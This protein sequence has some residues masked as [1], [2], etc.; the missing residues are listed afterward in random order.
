MPPPSKSTAKPISSSYSEAGGRTASNNL[1]IGNLNPEITDSDLVALFEK[2]GPVDS[3]TNYSARSYGFVYYK[4]IEDAK[5]AKE[6]LQGTILHGNPIKIEFAKPAKPCK[7]LWVAGISQSVSKEELEEEFMRFGKIQ[8]FKFLRDRNTAYVDY[9]KLEDAS[10][11]LKSMNGKRFGG[12]QI[13]VDFLRSQ[14]SRREH[15]PD[16]RDAREGQF[17]NRSIGPPDAQ[18]MGQDSMKVFSEPIHAGSKGHQFQSLG[19]RRGDGQPSKVLWISY[20]PSV[21]IEEDMLHNA[22]ILFGE[23]ERIKTFEDRNYAFVQFRSVDEARLAKEG[24][25]G[26]LF[27]DPRITIEYSNSDL[28]PSKDYLGNYPGTKGPMPDMHQNEVPFREKMDIIGHNP[29][30]LP[31]RGVPGPD[32]LLRSLG[33]QGNIESQ[34]GRHT[35]LGGPNWRRSPPAPG[36]LSSPSASLNLPNR[37]VSGAWDI[38]DASQLQRESKRSRVDRTLQTYDMSFPP[39]RADEQGLGLDEPYGLRTL[40]AAGFADSLSNFEGRNRLSPVD[41]QISASGLGKRLPEPDYVWQGIIAKGGSP[42]CRARC[43]PIGEGIGSHIPEVVNCTARTGLDMLTKHYADAVGYSV[44]FFLPDS[45]ADFASYT[46]FLRYLGARNRAGVAKFD[47][48][49]TLFLVPPSD[50]LTNVLKFDGPERLY[51]VVL[52]FPQAAPDSSAVQPPLHQMQYADAQQQ[53]IS[54]TV[55]NGTRQEATA[56]QVDYNR[57]N[58]EDMKPPLKMLGPSS[59]STPPINYAAVSQSGVSW[60]PELIATLASLLPGNNKSSGLGSSS[61]Q[62]ASSTLGPALNTNPAPDKGL[63]Q[64]WPHER[65][66]R[67]QTG[68][69]MQQ[70]SSH[71]YSQA[72]F[73]PQVQTYLPVSNPPNLPVQGV[74]GYNQMQDRGFNLQQQGSVPPATPSQGQ[75]S[76]L[77]LADQQH[78]LGIP[79]D[80]LKSHGIT[81][82][83]DA[84]TLYG[85]SVIQQPTNLVTLANEVNG[86]NVLQPQ[87]PMP[88]TTKMDVNNPVQELQAAVQTGQET[89]ETEDEKNRRYQSTLLFAANLLNKVQQ[90]PGT[91]TG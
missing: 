35:H 82:G 50:F 19:G 90:P 58:R 3:I 45:E 5:S 49:T 33:P 71:F 84:L 85:S 17:P 80:H 7:S 75:V 6:K 73:I 72:Q 34:G 37:S 78:Q 91:Q 54:Q 86:A 56:L 76:A 64:G 53:T 65:L 29:P 23:I 77:P 30:I 32:V 2:H 36:L 83:T 10:Q 67:E 12:D 16:L 62:S 63:M 57:A 39:R 61:V 44:A 79:Y 59:S 88:Q 20:P 87:A 26:K 55:Y 8:E 81:Q 25:Q 51:G 24:L 11:A 9:F 43:V 60:T 1:W 13:R 42:I 4:K 68:H 21:Q 40:S 48:G 46:E 66:V 38:F 41:V 14:P 27:S 52:E 15:L 47:D 18:W 70:V 89:S 69:P 74:I 31:P 28:G 22:M